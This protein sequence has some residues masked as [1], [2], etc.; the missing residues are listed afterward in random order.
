MTIKLL[1]CTLRDGGYLN[2]W[3]FGH[4]NIIWMFQKLQN[5]KIDII[6]LGYLRDYES[7]NIDRAVFPDTKSFKEMFKEITKTCPVSAMID[8]GDCKIENI[9]DKK[10]SFIDILRVT[11]RKNK[12][13]E[14]IDYC[15][16][17]KQKGYTIFLQPVSVTSYSDREMLDLIDKINDLKPE[18][19]SI[20][21]SYGLM[22]EEKVVRY[23]YL[24]DNNLLPEIG[25]AYHSHNNFQLAYSNSIKLLEKKCSRNLFFDASLYG[26]GKSAGN[27]N[28]ELLAMY[29][30]KNHNKNYD[31]NEILEIIDTQ[32]IKLTKLYQWG[33]QL[34]F[35]L[36]ALH[37][38]HP[39]YVHYL[40]EKNLLT[41]KDISKIISNIDKDK[42]LVFDR[43]Y[44]EKLYVDYQ[45][46][47]VDDSKIYSE[48]KEKLQNKTVLL[49]G[50]G[51]TVETEYEKIKNYI[52]TNNIITFSVN[53]IDKLFNTDYLFVSNAKRYS[54]LFNLY[55][56][57]NKNKLI[58]TSNIMDNREKADYI[59]NW[60]NLAVNDNEIGNSSLYLL[61]KFLIKLKIKKIVLA[62]FDGFSK[63]AQNYYDKNFEFYSQKNN[64]LVTNAIIE[65]IKEFQKEIE[66]EFLTKSKYQ[67]DKEVLNV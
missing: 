50:P 40:L 5:S 24:M 25:I 29:L 45:N 44:L 51:A 53:H 16:Q 60:N 61:T 49:I 10:N 57:N 8:F 31:I 17:L 63:Q 39:N 62:G 43:N 56:K 67:T 12:I 52:N 22:H 37:N 55:C 32:I 58:I 7:F 2:D 65:Q 15:K 66:I 27:C 19:L 20:V 3:D 30:N 4:D 47:Y 6:E 35:Y 41:V 36:S 48:L 26:M 28:I 54:N 34:P 18:A 13:D 64:T 1:D 46:R 33:Y 14:A 9:E 21:D 38:C 11:F 23:F 42:A 59:I